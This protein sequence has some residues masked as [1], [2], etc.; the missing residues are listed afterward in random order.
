MKKV[1]IVVMAVAMG[2][3]AVSCGN[4]AKSSDAENAVQ[5]LADEIEANTPDGSIVG[6]T[7]DAAEGLKKLDKT[8]FLPIVKGIYG[9]DITPDANWELKMAHSPN[10][11]NNVEVMWT[12]PGPIDGDAIKKAIFEQIL[13]I[14]EDGICVLDLDFNTFKLSKGDKLESYEDYKAKASG[15]TIYY[16]YK[17]EGIQADFSADSYDDASYIIYKFV[18]TTI[19]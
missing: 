4:K 12:N 6:Y 18:L 7:G 10:H 14:T 16:V 8:N 15:K 5:K 9:V 3:L 2:V 19:K 17:G 13:S 1:I 11:V